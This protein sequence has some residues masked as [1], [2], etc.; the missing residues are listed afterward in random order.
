MVDYGD[1]CAF[2]HVWLVDPS[3]IQLC[4]LFP[5]PRSVSACV[6]YDCQ[7]AFTSLMPV[8][9]AHGLGNP[10]RNSLP[11]CQ[12]VQLFSYANCLDYVVPAVYAA[13][14]VARA[15]GA[16]IFIWIDTL[17]IPVGETFRDARRLAI[18]NLDRTFR[19]AQRVIVLDTELR[20]AITNTSLLERGIRVFLSGWMRRVCEL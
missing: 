15:T 13:F 14:Q 7:K 2:S 5:F 17:C 18:S 12:L 10:S 11:L 8:Y 3:P 1:F 20:H 19:D 6:L 4:L 16:T 9:R